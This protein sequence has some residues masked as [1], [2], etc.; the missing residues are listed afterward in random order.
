MGIL[1]ELVQSRQF[2]D[3]QSFLEGEA[4]QPYFAALDSFVTEQ[5][6]QN[7]VY[8]PREKIF[9]ALKACPRAAVRAV[10]LGQDPYHEPG[11][12]QGLSF[13]VPEG[14]PLPRSLQ[15]IYK[16]LTADLGCPLPA[17]GDLTRW[18]RQGVLLLNTV[19][20]VNAGD[21][22]SHAGKGW[23][24]FT[25]HLLQQVDRL[26]QPV[27]FV[28]WGKPAQ[29]KLAFLTPGP[30]R[31]AVCSAHPSPLSARRGFFGSRPFSAVNGFLT[32]CGEP[33]IR[34]E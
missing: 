17:G 34:W 15:N 23:E 13:S 22:N 6:A 18:A 25:D 12:A 1:L 3:W 4:A 27:A 11:Q 33:E 10:I 32:S 14:F 24:T 20:T 5:Y 26:P 7:T 30:N 9:A 31:L 29:K 19:L 28:L 16:E 2:G 21:A 8:P